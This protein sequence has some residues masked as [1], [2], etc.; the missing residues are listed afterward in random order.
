MGQSDREWFM[1]KKP[2]TRPKAGMRTGFDVP[3]PG[4]FGRGGM[5]T[6]PAGQ[7]GWGAGRGAPPPAFGR[8]RW[9]PQPT[10]LGQRGPNETPFSTP[11]GPPRDMFPPSRQ[12][13]EFQPFAQPFTPLRPALHSPQH[14]IHPYSMPAEYGVLH[15]VM[16]VEDKPTEFSAFRGTL[17]FIFMTMLYNKVYSNVQI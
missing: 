6:P 13:Q 12:P 14:A 5:E 8:G 15:G 7:Y 11:P 16:D 4:P 17:C 1:K 2:N 10:E 9:G 3:P